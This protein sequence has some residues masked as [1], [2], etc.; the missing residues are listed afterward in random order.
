VQWEFDWHAYAVWYDPETVKR[1]GRSCNGSGQLI[2]RGAVAGYNEPIPSIRFKSLR[3]GLQ[4][5][6]YFWLLTQKTGSREAADSLVNG[7]IYKNPF[8]RT[9][10]GD[11]EI[12]KYNPDEWDKARLAAAAEL[13]RLIQ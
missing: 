5:Y 4:D 10:V 12:W 11:T 6:E 1:P 2:Y 8:G 13:V 7:V 9:S 3:R